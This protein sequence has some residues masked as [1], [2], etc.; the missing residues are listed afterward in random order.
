MG[1]K[2]DRLRRSPLTSTTVGK[3]LL[4]KSVEGS[5]EDD[6]E[7]TFGAIQDSNELAKARRSKAADQDGPKV[8]DDQGGQVLEAEKAMYGESNGAATSEGGVGSKI[9]SSVPNTPV[10]DAT[11]SPLDAAVLK[12]VGIH[13]SALFFEIKKVVA[14]LH[15]TFKSNTE[16]GLDESKQEHNA[17]FIGTEEE[18]LERSSGNILVSSELTQGDLSSIQHHLCEQPT[19]SANYAHLQAKFDDI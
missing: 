14:D 10:H 4:D 19:V 6:E 7:K 5:S 3:E 16:D 9:E 8:V 11:L 13:N 18:D 2:K 15:P 17:Q 12:R 1:G